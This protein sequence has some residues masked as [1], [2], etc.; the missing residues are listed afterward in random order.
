MRLE[1]AKWNWDWQ[2]WLTILLFVQAAV[3][4]GVSIRIMFW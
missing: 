4:L 2:D 1:K 3:A